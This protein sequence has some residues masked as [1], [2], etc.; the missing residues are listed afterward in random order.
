[1]RFLMSTEKYNI[2]K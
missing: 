1:L 2:S